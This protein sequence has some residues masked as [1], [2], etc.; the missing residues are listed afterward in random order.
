MI[1]NVEIHSSEL[2]MDRCRVRFIDGTVRT[3]KKESLIGY[4][5]KETHRGYIGIKELKRKKCL[6]IQCKYLKKCSNGFWEKR[7]QEKNRIA[8]HKRKKRDKLY[9][10]KI[11]Q[12]KK[13]IILENARNIASE[14]K[15]NIVFLGLYYI[16]DNAIRITFISESSADDSENFS[17]LKDVISKQINKKIILKHIQDYN[18]KHYVT[19][20][21]YKRKG[22][23]KCLDL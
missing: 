16:S 12:K 23:K 17:E 7:E 22:D 18:D 8:E 5:Q 13:N 19:I 2:D 21:E 20:T 6:K 9:N 3:V 14:M 4:C 11:Q 10:Q 15:L 1:D